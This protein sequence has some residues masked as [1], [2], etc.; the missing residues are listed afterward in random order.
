MTCAMMVA[1][2]TR[3]WSDDDFCPTFM[4]GNKLLATCESPSNLDICLGYIEGVA[5]EL[6]SIK[7]LKIPFRAPN[8]NMVIFMHDSSC[9]PLEV[10]AGQAKD[11]VVQ[12][13]QNHPE[14]RHLAATTSI[15]LALEKAFPCP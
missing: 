3:G 9:R 8:G 1:F 4:N 10:T 2:S 12:Y 5:D 11:V 15:Y 13:L 14:L 6:V 7:S